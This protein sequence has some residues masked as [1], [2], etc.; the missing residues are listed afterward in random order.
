MW[1][2]FDRRRIQVDLTV[3]VPRASVLAADL[4]VGAMDVRGVAGAIDVHVGTGDLRVHDVAAGASVTV[5]TGDVRIELAPSWNGPRLM[6]R[7]KIGDVRITAASGLRARVDAH[8][9]LGDVH[10]ALAAASAGA[11]A[12]LIDARTNVGDVSIVTR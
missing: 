6:A 11:A 12:P 8:T 5:G 1:Q 10:N 3:A 9:R 4:P 2:L 7:S